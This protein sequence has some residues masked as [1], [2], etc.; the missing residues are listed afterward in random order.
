MNGEKILVANWKSNLS[1]SE[2]T[3]WL[4]TFSSNYKQSPYKIIV[5]PAFTQL[6]TVQEKSIELALPLEFGIQDISPFPAGSYTGAISPQNLQGFRVRYAIVGHSE[7]RRHFHE[8]SADVAKKII[9]C[10]SA[11]ITPI[12]CVDAQNVTEQL[13]LIDQE[14]LSSCIFAYEDPQHIGT[15]IPSSIQDVEVVI[16]IICRQAGADA[17]ILYGGSANKTTAKEF[18]LHPALS[19][20]LIGSSSLSA[21]EFCSLSALEK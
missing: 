3:T 19:G 18:L 8:T 1:V 10:H 11:S 14:L 4:T 20:L 7:R 16:D 9:Q 17:Q 15:G 13:T 2:A 6:S 5:C 12:V 21:A